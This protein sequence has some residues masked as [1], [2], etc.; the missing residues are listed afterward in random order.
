MKG[1]IGLV[2]RKVGCYLLWVLLQ[3]EDSHLCPSFAYL[4]LTPE[5]LKSCNHD[6][7]TFG[8]PVCNSQAVLQ[9]CKEMGSKGSRH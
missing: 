7:S 3:P 4:T 1:Y 5:F 9:A 6:L 8:F 2:V